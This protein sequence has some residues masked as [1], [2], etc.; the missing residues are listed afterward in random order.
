MISPLRTMEYLTETAQLVACTPHYQSCP[1]L[2][3]L[4]PTRLLFIA[5]ACLDRAPLPTHNACSGFPCSSMA[6]LCH[7]PLCPHRVCAPHTIV[8][9][10]HHVLV[11][12]YSLPFLAELNQPRTNTALFSRMMQSGSLRLGGP[13]IISNPL[14]IYLLRTSRYSLLSTHI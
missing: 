3:R 2:P 12:T 5:G 13:V 14:G 11:R 10:Q 9:I 7:R 4:S 1:H 8:G 6:F